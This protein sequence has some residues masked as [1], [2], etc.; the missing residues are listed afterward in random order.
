MFTL[1]TGAAMGCDFLGTDL[2][3]IDTLKGRKDTAR[4]AAIQ[5]H[6]VGLEVALRPIEDTEPAPGMKSKGMSF[7]EINA[8]MLAANK[9]A[10]ALS[11]KKLLEISDEIKKGSRFPLGY[12]ALAIL[13]LGIVLH[14]V[15][16]WHQV[17]KVSEENRSRH[18]VS[19][20]RCA[21][22]LRSARKRG[23]AS[24]ASPFCRSQEN[25]RSVEDAIREDQGSETEADRIAAA[26]RARW[27]KV[28]R[29]G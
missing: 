8:I 29:A 22:H 6:I 4:V 24:V 25:Q 26:Q 3:F 28:K 18:K 11:K 15:E 14:G 12:V 27:A 16:G 20:S 13:A 19:L 2:V 7:D 9:D 10:M 21:A 1:I 23:I 17:T 5:T